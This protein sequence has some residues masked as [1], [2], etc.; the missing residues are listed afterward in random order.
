MDPDELSLIDLAVELR[1]RQLEPT[2]AAE[3]LREAWKKG[4]GILRE[5]RP[6]SRELPVIG[7]AAR[8]RAILEKP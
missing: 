8:T 4:R 3:R 7:L 1:I 2:A 6:P 5:R